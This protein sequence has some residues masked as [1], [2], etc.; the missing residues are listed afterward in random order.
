V[1]IFV[2][3]GCTFLGSKNF[4]LFLDLFLVLTNNRGGLKN[5]GAGQALAELGG[6]FAVT[7][8]AEGAEVVEVALA[9][10]FGYGPD[11]VGVPQ[12]ST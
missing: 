11:V 3:L 9:T 12:A 1:V 2:V 4:P 5:S 8:E 7:E 10:A 6:C